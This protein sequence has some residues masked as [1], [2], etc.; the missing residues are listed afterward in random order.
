MRL[1][2]KQRKTAAPGLIETLRAPP[3]FETYAELA[4]E[5]HEADRLDALRQGEHIL[6]PA[7]NAGSGRGYTLQTLVEDGLMTSRFMQGSFV[8]RPTV[9]GLRFLARQTER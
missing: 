3:D 1:P 8:F 5:E 9:E 6:H 2:W 7:T 4:R